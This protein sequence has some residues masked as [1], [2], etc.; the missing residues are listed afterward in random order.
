MAAMAWAKDTQW[1]LEASKLT[2][3]ET[4]KYKQLYAAHMGDDY[5][6]VKQ[7]TFMKQP[8]MIFKPEQFAERSANVGK[9]HADHVKTTLR[10]KLAAFGCAPI[11]HHLQ[12]SYDAAAARL[13]EPY[14]RHHLQRKRRGKKR[15]EYCGPTG[16][17]TYALIWL[18]DETEASKDSLYAC[19]CRIVVR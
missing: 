4:A 16:I 5:K 9:M 7:L 17:P 19:L 12:A 15:T 10:Q 3:Q 11:P 13:A 6:T 8:K 18:E 2:D 14:T 1:R